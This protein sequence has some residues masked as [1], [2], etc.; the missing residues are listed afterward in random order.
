MCTR[1][2]IKIF[3]NKLLFMSTLL[4]LK[5]INLKYQTGKDSISVLKNIDLN[6]KVINGSVS[7]STSSG[8]LNRADWSLSEPGIDLIILGLGANDMLRG[9]QPEETEKNLE[10]IIKVAQNKK[11]KIILAGMMAPDTHGEKYK[12]EFDAIYPKLSKK[13][14]LALIPFLLEGVALNP[15][16]NQQDGI[17]PNKDGT[18]KVSETIKKSIINIIN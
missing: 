7:G 13:Y 5:K 17:H 6:I 9:I 15:S 1:K 4:K 3:V 8:G 10:K 12:K 16:L 14:N 18:I 2:I 11:I